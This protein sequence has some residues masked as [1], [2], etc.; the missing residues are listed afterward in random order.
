MG[1][2]SVLGSILSNLASNELPVKP[3]LQFLW[4]LLGVVT[5]VLIG[6]ALLQHRLQHTTEHSAPTLSSQNRQRMLDRVRAFW[7]KGVLEQSLHGAALIALGLHEQPDAVESPWRLV[8]Q[9]PDQS[10]SPLPP[11]TRIWQVYD[12]A[13]GELLILGEPGSGKT[14][15]LLEL[16]RD[17]LDRAQRDDTHP[18][19]VVFNLSSW[20]VKRQSIA[21]WMVEEPN[22]KYQVPRKLGRSWV[23]ADQ[24]LPL[25]DGLDEVAKEYCAACVDAINAYRH[26]HMV[27]IVVCSRSTEYLS[28]TSRVQV[29]CAVVVQPLTTQQIDDYLAS[30]GGLLAAVRVALRKDTVLQEL[31]ATPLMLSVLT[32]AYHGKSVEEVIVA[33]S[34]E[35]QR[36]QV[37]ATYVQRMLQRR[38]ASAYYTP[39]QTRHWLTWLAVQLSDGSKE[40]RLE[41]MN[42]DW[43]PEGRSRQRYY[44]I[45]IGMIRG[46]LV[47]LLKGLLSGL[48]VGLLKGLL[49]GLL[50]GLLVGVLS[51]LVTGLLNRLDSR[52]FSGI[53]VGLLSGLIIG[54]YAGGVSGWVGGLVGGGVGWWDGRESSRLR[55]GSIGL[56]EGKGG[57][58]VGGLLDGLALGLICWLAVTSQFGRIYGLFSG[59]IYGL[60]SGL[61]AGLVGGLIGFLQYSGEIPIGYIV[62]RLLL[63]RAGYIPWNYRR[64]LDYA[65]ERILLRKIGGGYIFIHRLLQDYIASLDTTPI[66]NKQTQSM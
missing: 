2:L 19:P 42:P 5:L 41:R 60:F 66:T 18:M 11:G 4:P 21:D 36:R 24:I 61:F 30:A 9:Q 6:L 35:I 31:A 49:S 28:Q 12:N 39:E 63:W 54:L 38:G 22:T 43:L 23:G 65:T 17:R 47:G 10:T 64:F 29:R 37:F 46:L 14:T 3:Y 57:M 59:L 52:L 20:A 27:P 15:L 25:L 56:F 26:E 13:G 1:L 33:G 16:A 50:V 51:W 62:L 58:V 32:L 55:R 45:V 53:A 40:F 44:T 34:H 7:I 48:L 8:L